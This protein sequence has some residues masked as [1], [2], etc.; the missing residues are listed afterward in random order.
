M[1]EK[2][3]KFVIIALAFNILIFPVVKYVNNN[4]V[5]STVSLIIY[6]VLA[7][8]TMWFYLFAKGDNKLIPIKY[9][10]VILFIAVVMTVL[11][12]FSW[13]AV[14]IAPNIGYPLLILNGSMIFVTLYAGLIGKQS[15]SLNKFL[16]VLLIFMGI[17]MVI[18]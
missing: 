9:F 18:L 3:L 17:L 5:S 11:T 4:G 15:L 13:E 8:I 2:W 12:L 14:V 10:L 7:S 6:V 1:I 16:S